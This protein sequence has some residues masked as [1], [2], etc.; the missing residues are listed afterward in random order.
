M[1]KFLLFLVAATSVACSQD[2]TTDA[3]GKGLPIDFRAAVGTRA[4]EITNDKISEIA[5][6]AIGEAGVNYFDNV[7][8]SKSGSY[9]TSEYP[10]YWPSDG[11]TLSFYAYAPTPL[12][13]IEGGSVT[14]K[15]DNKTVDYTPDSD[16]SLQEDFITATATGNKTANEATS[17]TLA[18]GHRLSQIEVKAKNSNTSN[19]YKVQGVCIAWPVSTA[20]FDFDKCTWV[21]GVD[22]ITY[23]VTYAGSE[24]TLGSE[25][26]SIMGADD[27]A[28]L[29]PQKLT[30]WDPSSDKTNSSK[31]AY[32]SVLINITGAFEY[33]PSG[34]YGWAAVPIDTNW[35]AGKKYIYTLDFSG[36]AGKVDPTLPGGGE[37][38]MG[39]PIKFSVTVDAWQPVEP[40]S[41]INM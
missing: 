1:K 9:F 11:S 33:P 29:I 26:V 34:G 13:G 41:D 36:G 20:T 2:E 5:V 17:V 38:I 7:K 30:A 18:F 4:M 8:F 6:T 27:N 24:K 16:I 12:T 32:L 23:E 28:M 14:I 19:V 10:Y 22:K 15:S 35:E 40:S 31:G 3:V 39:S 25:A 37:D 21:L